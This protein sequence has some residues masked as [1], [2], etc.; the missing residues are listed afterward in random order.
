MQKPPVP[1]GGGRCSGCRGALAV[2]A[3]P[4]RPETY[5]AASL[6]SS[7]ARPDFLLAALFL[8]MTCL[9]AALS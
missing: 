6:F 4:G 5:L 8:W 3:G 1:T 7:A 9:V 2:S